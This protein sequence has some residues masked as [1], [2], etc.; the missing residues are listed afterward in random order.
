VHHLSTVSI[1][2]CDGYD[3]KKVMQA[4]LESFRNLGGLDKYIK[5][6]MKVALKANLLMDKPP[7]SA[8]TTHPA[9]VKAV[10][11]IAR[12][13]A[14]D[15]LHKSSIKIQTKKVAGPLFYT[16]FR[17]FYLIDK[18]AESCKIIYRHICQN[19]SVE[20]DSGLFQSVYKFA[21]G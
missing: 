18:L 8:V 2:K 13:A 12:A 5:P 19:L 9:V 6:G 21:V 10:S 15:E 20:V 1:V 14:C 16:L 3:D 11:A 17:T 7:S 4:V